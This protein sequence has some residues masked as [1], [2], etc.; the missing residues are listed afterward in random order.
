MTRGVEF[1]M[2]WRWIY[3]DLPKDLT[4]YKIEIQ[5]RPFEKSSQVI[6]TFD[7]TSSYVTVNDLDGM[8]SINLPPSIT[9]AYTFKTAAIDCWLVNNGDTDGERSPSYNINLNWGV[10]R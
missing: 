9:L 7:R 1:Y 8:V 6:A 4:D 5:I 10:A 2:G 3:G